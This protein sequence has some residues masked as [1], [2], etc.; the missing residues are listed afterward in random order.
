MTTGLELLEAARNVATRAAEFLREQEGRVRPEA[1]SAKGRAD[2]VTE[3]DRESERMIAAMLMEAVPGSIVVGE[4]LSP[5]APAARTPNPVF[6]VDPL[7]GTTNFLHRFPMYAVSIAA[8]VNGV[9][10]AGCVVHVTP[11]ITYT[12]VRGG[13]ARQDGRPIAV[14]DIAEPILALIGTGFPY[15]RMEQLPLYQRQFATVVAGAGGVRRPGSAALDLCDV[16]A[17]R[18]DGFWELRLAPWDV[19]AG[20][21]MIREAGGVVTDLANSPDLLGHSAIVAGNPAIHEWLLKVLPQ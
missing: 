5:D 4:E 6:I 17:G 8:T 2:Y 11:G 18:Y 7:D 12:A 19:A 3:V 13:G 21:L 20:V 16:A 1:W 15:N 14:S 9:L 10:E